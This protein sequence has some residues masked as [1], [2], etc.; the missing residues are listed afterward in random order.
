MN[1]K[2][3]TGIVG[4]GF[5]APWHANAIARIPNVEITCVCDYSSSTAQSLAGMFGVK[6]VYTDI[7]EMLASGKCDAVHILTP[8]NAH[9]EGAKKALQNGLHVLVEKPFTLDPK[10]SAELDKLAR[11]NDLTLAVNHNFL[12]LPSYEKL[13]Q[14]IENGDIGRIDSLDI[15][16]RF[17]LAPLRSGPF[18]LWLIREPKNLLLELGPHLFA[19]ARD[20]AGDLDNIDVRVSKEIELPSGIVVPQSWQILARS[21]NV[22]ITMNISLVEGYDERTLHVRGVCGKAILDYGNDTLEIMRENTADIV[23]NPLAKQLSSAKNRLSAGLYNAALQLKSLNQLSPYA[24]SINGAVSTFYE[25]IKERS[26]MD[27]RFSA[28][29]ATAVIYSIISAAKIAEAKLPRSKKSVSNSGAKKGAAKKEKILVIGG[30]GF[31]GRSLVN[32]L[33]SEGYKV[34]VF[35]RGRSNNF[36]LLGKSV[37]IVTGDLKMENDLRKAMKGMDYVFHL[38]RSEE[39]SWENYLSNDVNVTKLIGECCEKE[40]VKRLIYTGT[41]DSY[42][43]S[44]KDNTISED[45]GFAR[46]MTDRNLYA[47]SKAMCESVLLSLSQ[48]GKLP[49]VIIRPGIV[50]GKG[51]PLQHWGIGR[52]NGSGACKIW[53]DGNNILPFVLVEDV[54]DGL[55]KAMTT[56]NIEGASFNLIGDPILSARGYF[57]VI[58]KNMGVRL[59]IRKGTPLM[60]FLSGAMKYFLKKHVL[61]K[62]GLFLSSYKDW[63]S[64]AH[65]SIFANEKSKEILGWEPENN[66]E[67]FIEKAV[68]GANLFGY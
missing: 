47:R 50:V 7:D 3:R 6:N 36:D 14:S 32:R 37:E 19:F 34:K 21:G 8:P 63:K 58:H 61:R 55:L 10:E 28:E 56:P 44:A 62:K 41:I 26:L 57:D 30:T 2:I 23:V 9:F 51:G 18:G 42:D 38:A 31:I 20:I 5:I 54:A 40:K 4:A 12:A 1:D 27:K 66:R 68:I 49:L 35:S 33:A 25:A 53:G 45:T 29:S 16:W 46:D 13:K 15:N 65:Y 60:F 48:K 22:D 17:P 11:A 43:T 59:N 24:L 64:R 52:W 39:A 67:K